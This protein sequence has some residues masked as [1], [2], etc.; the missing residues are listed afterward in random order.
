MGK[1]VNAA[2]YF[3]AGVFAAAYCPT[4]LSDAEML[5]IERAMAQLGG[6]T[7]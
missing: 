4:A 5:I 1:A 3:N 2:R 6:I 7:I